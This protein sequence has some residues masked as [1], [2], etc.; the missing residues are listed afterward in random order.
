MSDPHQ[1]N[2]VKN[3]ISNVRVKKSEDLSRIN[4]YLCL[5]HPAVCASYVGRKMT[6]SNEKPWNLLMRIQEKNIV[7]TIMTPL[8]VRAAAVAAARAHS[9]ARLAGSIIRYNNSNNNNRLPRCSFRA[10]IAHDPSVGID[11]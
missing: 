8:V 1:L 9:L 6:I 5:N 2:E 4:Q 3:L 7:H 11:D 10:P